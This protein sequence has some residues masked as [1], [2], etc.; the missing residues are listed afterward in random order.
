MKSAI[1]L[2][3]QVFGDSQKLSKLI[4]KQTFTVLLKPNVIWYLCKESINKEISWKIMRNL[5]EQNIQKEIFVQAKT[6]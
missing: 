1:L 2:H 5:C 4:K 6:F 3:E